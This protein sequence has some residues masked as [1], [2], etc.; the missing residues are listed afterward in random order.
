MTTLINPEGY[1]LLNNLSGGVLSHQKKL[2]FIEGCNV[3]NTGFLTNL[4]DLGGGGGQN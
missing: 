2:I 1:M 3:A 4:I